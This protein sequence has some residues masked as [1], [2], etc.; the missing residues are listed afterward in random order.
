MK[1][2]FTNFW[3]V[4]FVLFTSV[5]LASCSDEDDEPTLSGNI[6]GEWV[7]EGE[8]VTEYLKF[9]SDNT[10]V[11]TIELS[12]TGETFNYPFEYAYTYV[13]AEG[14]GRCIIRNSTSSY[15]ADGNYTVYFIGN[16][17]MDFG[18][19]MFTRR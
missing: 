14:Q 16:N 17:K 19:V 4:L 7:N 18:G 15:T 9:N 13:D 8:Y 5:S 10:G 1:K 12:Q 6:V 2:L 3:I 11:N